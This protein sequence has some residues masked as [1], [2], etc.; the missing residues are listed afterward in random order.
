MFGITGRC[1]EAPWGH[2]PYD[3]A[4]KQVMTVESPRVGDSGTIGG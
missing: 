3:L 4:L 2:S 1:M